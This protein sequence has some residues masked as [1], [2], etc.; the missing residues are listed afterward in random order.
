MNLCSFAGRLARWSFARKR[1]MNEQKT[2]LPPEL[3]RL[4]RIFQPHGVES[5]QSAA[6]RN[7]RFV[8][9][10]SADAAMNILR[11]KVHAGTDRIRLA[12]S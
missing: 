12:T 6:A 5:N 11:A 3:K 2:Q 9:Y 1:V 10:T 8:H 7:I 4:L